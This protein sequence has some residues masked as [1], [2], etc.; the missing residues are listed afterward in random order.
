MIFP[1]IPT[2]PCNCQ[3]VSLCKNK[4]RLIGKDGKDGKRRLL[5]I[6]WSKASG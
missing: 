5:I 6:N 1:T 3:S 4:L 2:F